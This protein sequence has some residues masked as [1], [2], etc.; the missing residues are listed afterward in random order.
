MDTEPNGNGRYH[1][2]AEPNGNGRHH[3]QGERSLDNP[4]IDAISGTK[5]QEIVDF[6]MDT[7]PYANMLPG[8]SNVRAART[9]GQGVDEGRKGSRVIMAVSLFLLIVLVAPLVLGLLQHF[10][11]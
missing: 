4:Y 6:E 3:R 9:I 5:P 8:I 11:H 1:V 7:N 10:V 2:D